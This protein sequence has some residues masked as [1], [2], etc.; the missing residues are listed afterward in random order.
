M[1]EQTHTILLVEDELNL[2]F[3]LKLNLEAE[4]YQVTHASTGKQAVEIFQKAD[5]FAAIILDVMLPEISGFDVAHIV[6]GIDPRV[7]ILMLTARASDE[8]RVRGFESGVDDYLTKP[9]HLPELLLRVKRMSQRNQLLNQAKANSTHS[10]SSKI[11]LGEYR[12]DQE[13]LTFTS[14][15]GTFELTEIESGMLREFLSQPQK[16]LS[17][18]YLLKHVWGIDGQIETR[19]VDN[20]ILRL[21]RMIEKKPKSP[22]VLLSIRGRGYRLNI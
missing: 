5:Q 19:T 14:S 8:D 20:F 10:E 6:R 16:T 18:E 2:A 11:A 7:G 12:L 13:A 9:F 22:K 21:R 1:T 4:G 3:N 17:R 15:M